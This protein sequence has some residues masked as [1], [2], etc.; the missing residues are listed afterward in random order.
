MQPL[1]PHLGSARIGR[2][3]AGV[4]GLVVVVV[5]LL[6][7]AHPDGRL[8]AYLINGVTGAF[9]VFGAVSC[10]LRARAEPAAARGFRILGVTAGVGVFVAVGGIV[11]LAANPDPRFSP[12]YPSLGDWFNVPVLILLAIGSLGWPGTAGTKAPRGQTA[13]DGAIF[14]VSCFMISWA[15]AL[16]DLT[17]ASG[18]VPL[19]KAAAIGTWVGVTFDLGIIVYVCARR[20]SLYAGPVGMVGLGVLLGAVNTLLLTVLALQGRYYMGH[21]VD[22][23]GL[24]AYTASAVAPWLPARVAAGGQAAQGA[25]VRSPTM[26]DALPYLPALVCL[27]ISVQH[28][29]GAGSRDLVFIGLA[30]AV[31]IL[32]LVRQFLSL[33]QVR[34]LSVDLEQKVAERTAELRQSHEA[35]AKSQRMETVATLAGGIAH[36]FNNMLTVVTGGVSAARDHMPEAGQRALDLIDQAAARAAALTRQLLTFARRQV[37]EARIFSPA[38]RL[39]DLD[40]LIRRAIGDAIAVQ[41]RIEGDP[42]TVRMDPGQFEQ[43]VMNLAVNARDAMPTGGILIIGLCRADREA[44]VRAMGDR[45]TGSVFVCLTVQDTGIGMSEAVKARIFEPFFTTKGPD[46]GTGLGLATTYGIIETAG[47]AILVDSAP[48]AGTRFELYLPVTDGPVLP[49]PESLAPLAAARGSETLLV[50]ED[51]PDVRALLVMSL[52]EQ[53]YTVLQ[54]AD[55]LEAVECARAFA[56]RIALI[57]C[58]VTMPRLGGRDAVALIR[59]QRHQISALFISGYQEDESIREALSQESANFLAKPFSLQALHGRVRE[60]LAADGYLSP[61]SR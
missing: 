57:V 5:A 3:L 31:F 59:Q 60:L 14:G 53:G 15:L 2:A 29:L 54:A 6:A 42:G 33:R 35:L 41:L 34:A 4:A 24:A 8:S 13:L 50:V 61:G 10:Y 28:L 45:R 32:I 56:G 43:V 52:G 47:G 46:Q 37:I 40:K 19:A 23:F 16:G 7:V 48:G 26:T 12:V 11:T 55:G 22:L 27:P 21:V 51:D 1:S 58:D 30:G 49:T 9:A 36:D 17:A 44:T 25:V 39:T 18:I 38:E 20:P